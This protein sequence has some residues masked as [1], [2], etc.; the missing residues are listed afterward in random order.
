VDDEERILNGLRTLFRSKYHVFTADNGAQALEFVKRFGIHVVVSDQRMPGM[1]G[2]ELLRQVKDASPSSVRMLLTGYSDLAS[3]VGSIN[4]GEVYRF[5]KKPWDNEEMLSTIADAAAIAL[6][7]ATPKAP[8]ANAPVRIDA[9][10]LVID[11]GSALAD[12]LRSLM[13]A[14]APVRLAASAE[15]AVKVLETEAVALIVA[16]LSAGE[17]PLVALFEQL[18]AKRPEILSILVTESSDSE[19]VIELI[20]QAHIFRFLNKPI[21]VRQ[22]R[23]HVEAALAKYRA[24]MQDPALARQ[25]KVSGEATERQSALGAKLLARIQSLPGRIISPG[26]GAGGS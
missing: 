3:I 20:N 10:I 22:M 7:L 14:V 18:K 6:D 2:V 21:Q 13:A 5:V 8:A 1:T 26:P 25:Q 12:G 4:E 15:E 19:L 11:S 24:F 23:T 17:E 9:A 16:D